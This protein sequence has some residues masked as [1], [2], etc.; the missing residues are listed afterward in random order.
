V[1]TNLGQRDTARS[2]AGYDT[3]RPAVRPP[4]PAWFMARVGDPSDRLCEEAIEV[5]RAKAAG[6]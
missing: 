1:S 6:H 4:A 2:P 3:V 5:A